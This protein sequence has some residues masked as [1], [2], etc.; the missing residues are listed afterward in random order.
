MSKQIFRDL[1]LS[2]H[3]FIMVVWLLFLFSSTFAHLGVYETSGFT[4]SDAFLAFFVE[5][6]RVKISP[7]KMVERI[8]VQRC[9][10]WV[11]PATLR[12]AMIDVT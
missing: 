3:P 9:P 12:A 7:L 10:S 8:K 6:N 1:Q 4:V 5:V 2:G 11:W